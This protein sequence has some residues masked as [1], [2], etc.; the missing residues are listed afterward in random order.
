[1]SRVAVDTYLFY[2][3]ADW[4]ATGQDVEEFLLP[5][6]PQIRD[7]RFC[8]GD[9]TG[10]CRKLKDF[11][12]NDFLWG[13][14]AR[15]EIY[16]RILSV[17]DLDSR[18]VQLHQLILRRM[19]QGA[20]APTDLS[21]YR[22]TA[23][24]RADT[25][26][27]LRA[28]PL[29][30]WLLRHNGCCPGISSRR[31]SSSVKKADNK[32]EKT[33][34][35]EGHK[36]RS[37]CLPSSAPGCGSQAIRGL[38]TRR[39]SRAL[40]PAR[41]SSVSPAISVAAAATCIRCP[42]LITSCV[43]SLMSRGGTRPIPPLLISHSCMGLSPGHPPPPLETPEHLHG[44]FSTSECPGRRS[45]SRARRGIARCEAR[46]AGIHSAPLSEF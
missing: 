40:I 3:D 14:R 39:V 13:Q 44:V 24:R 36:S 1:M 11:N 27:V 22:Q 35:R 25:G 32:W 9:G 41:G 6:L 34:P 19:Q 46:A 37:R 5:R 20:A 10:D 33:R 26:V 28:S 2:S 4:L 8:P 12:H 38:S 15:K 30:S 17:L 45:I 29:I 16:E 7:A 42:D 31:T 23:T 43:V 21:S 18:K